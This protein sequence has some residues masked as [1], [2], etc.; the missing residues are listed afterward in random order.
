MRCTFFD[1][2]T[3]M[4]AI[5]TEQ[6]QRIC[7]G[8]ITSTGCTE[9]D[10]ACICKSSGW[11]SLIS[12][13]VVQAC[14]PQNLTGTFSR[15]RISDGFSESTYSLLAVTQFAVNLCQ[16]FDVQVN[17]QVTCASTTVT[18]I[19]SGSSSPTLASTMSTS[20]S[21]GSPLTPTT[22]GGLSTGA[23]V[24]IGVGVSLAAIALLSL[25][26]LCLVRRK[27]QRRVDRQSPIKLTE[28]AKPRQRGG[29]EPASDKFTVLQGADD[30]NLHSVPTNSSTAPPQG[31]PEAIYTADST[32]DTHRVSEHTQPVAASTVTATSSNTTGELRNLG[33]EQL[34][35]LDTADDVEIA[36]T[37]AK[38]ARIQERRM[39]LL[40]LQHLDDVE[41][42][43]RKELET[44]RAEISNGL[45]G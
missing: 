8:N 14:S 42:Q 45:R 29:V 2:Q 9:L 32:A 21:M 6:I 41:E 28:V 7:V 34:A 40:E 15:P 23:Q 27:V 12:C 33:Q 1:F 44:R 22:R 43:L 17:T 31:H 25:C 18:A 16:N 13:C 26:A 38:L 19:L 36:R 39:R 3:Y 24:G 30:R 4:D 11:I 10:I 20:S 37:R 5:F 35:E